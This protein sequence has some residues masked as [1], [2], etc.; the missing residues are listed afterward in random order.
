MF[1]SKIQLRNF[2]C[3]IEKDICFSAPITVITGNNGIGKTSIIE[4]IN[5]LCYFKSFRSHVITD[6]ITHGNDS[7]F[8]KGCFVLPQESEIEHVIQVGYSHKKKLIKLD[9]KNV[10]SYKETLP[11]FKVI[12]IMEDDIGI[13]KDAPSARRAFIDQA[14]LFSS[15]DHIDQYKDFK[16]ILH[17]RNSLLYAA[18]GQVEKL[19]KVEFEIWSE[20]LLTSS[21][22]IQELRKKEMLSIEAMI[23][24]FLHDYF[25]EVYEVKIAY[26]NKIPKSG[27]KSVLTQELLLRRSIFGA[28]LDDLVFHIKD[29]K[30]RVFASRGQQKLVALLCK[31]SLTQLNSKEGVL[32]LVLIDDFISDFDKVRLNKLIDLLFSCKSQLILTTPLCDQELELL[33]EKAGAHVIRLNE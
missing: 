21:I 9:Q 2:R 20:Q 18:H 10:S 22:L 28:H 24:G 11:Y 31:L 6:F 8:L 7:F 27:Y 17:N 1:L 19:D 14:V 23:N 3:F 15:P 29:K 33:V 26:E 25:E 4:A 30:A 13:I 32:P 16:R 5:Y 12:T